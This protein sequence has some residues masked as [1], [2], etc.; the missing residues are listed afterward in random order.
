[1]GNGG[2]S[3]GILF[4]SQAHIGSRRSGFEPHESVFG[5]LVATQLAIWATRTLILP[6]C[7]CPPLKDARE[8]SLESSPSPNQ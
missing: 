7:R 1:M 3:L 5:L 6:Q 2:D 8:D 4:F